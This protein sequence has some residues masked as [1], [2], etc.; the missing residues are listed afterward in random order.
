MPS[1]RCNNV[2]LFLEINYANL[3]FAINNAL[4]YPGKEYLVMVFVRH[5]I[6][7]AIVCT[8]Y[9]L[10]GFLSPLGTRHEK[11]ATNKGFEAIAPNF[12]SF[13]LGYPK[14]QEIPQ[15]D[16]RP[17]RLDSTYEEYLGLCKE[18]ASKCDC[19]QKEL[20]Q[21]I[22]K[23][24][25]KQDAERKEKLGDEKTPYVKPLS[26]DNWWGK[27]VIALATAFEVELPQ[28]TQ[29]LTRL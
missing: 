18:F 19:A 26:V 6:D 21:R 5:S 24:I 3:H 22:V 25:L 11:G 23:E 8:L 27:V 4:Y 28:G 16:L 1:L 7:R 15:E 13:A 2:I 29:V 12:V 20:A 10:E 9:D 14:D 17:G